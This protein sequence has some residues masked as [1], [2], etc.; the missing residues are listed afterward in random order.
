MKK[1][2]NE[3][4][5]SFYIIVWNFF[6]GC[7]FGYIIEIII[8]LFKYGKFV[9][10]QG[11]IFGPFNQIYGFGVVL[12]IIFLYKFRNHHII[13][14]FLISIVLGT[15]FEYLSSFF[16]EAFLGYITW[17]YSKMPFN[18]QGRVCLP[19]S[20]LWGVIGTVYIKYLYPL[21]P[22][23]LNK[24]NRKFYKIFALLF[25]VFMVFDIVYSSLA[26]Q[27]MKE[28]SEGIPAGNY[29]EIFM[30]ENY[31]DDKLKE[32]FTSIKFVK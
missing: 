32:I 6:F 21:V 14:V 15:V 26:I 29:I 17:D 12:M 23:L 18:F 3:K 25:F 27:R 22:K 4:H 20:L 30:D 11:V 19:F 8:F 13:S 28:R 2:E 7:I 24:L 9:N 5:I 16:V 10:R 31:P 1:P